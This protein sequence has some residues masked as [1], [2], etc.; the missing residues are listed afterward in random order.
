LNDA[1]SALSVGGMSAASKAVNPK[2]EISSAGAGEEGAG[3]FHTEL[4]SRMDQSRTSRREP[5]EVADSTEISVPDSSLQAAHSAEQAVPAGDARDRDEEQAS[6]TAEISPD[7][8]PSSDA[9]TQAALLVQAG[10]QAPLSMTCNAPKAVSDVVF[11]VEDQIGSPVSERDGQV[12]SVAFD[13]GMKALA[14]TADRAATGQVLPPESSGEVAPPSRKE[15]VISL[16]G[17][18][19]KTSSLYAEAGKMDLVSRFASGQEG[20]GAQFNT[21]TGGGASSSAWDSFCVQMQGEGEGAADKDWLKSLAGVDVVAPKP[22]LPLSSV[23]V[24]FRASSPS[25]TWQLAVESPVRSPA[26]AQELGDRLVW[27]SSGRQGQH[28]AEIS[29]NPA[30][31][32]PVEVKLS[33]SGGQASAQFFSP[34]PQVREAIEAAMP[35]LREMLAEAGV[36]LGQANVQDQSLSREQVFSGQQAR[37]EGEGRIDEVGEHEKTMQIPVRRVALG[38]VDLYA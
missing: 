12:P 5:V 23:E 13:Q 3:M 1:L 4:T 11:I 25:G 14:A 31:L 35:K 26:F 10:V 2:G 27:M 6:E 37:R 7:S 28:V 32:G 8:P 24:P 20:T 16:I 33:V 34:H 18:Q 15:S 36:A 30:N 9:A 29:L 21:S 17:G 19:G 22:G 38:R